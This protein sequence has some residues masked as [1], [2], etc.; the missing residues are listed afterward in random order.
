MSPATLTPRRRAHAP[1]EAQG[2]SR[3]DVALLVAWRG[4]GELAHGRFRELWRFV[5]PGD[6][7][8]VNTSATLPAAL[9]G[10]VDGLAVELNL[11][12]QAAEGD[13]IVELRTHD[14]G[15]FGPPPIGA[16]VELPAGARAHLLAPYAGGRRLCLARLSL[17]YPLEDYLRRHGRPI[18]YPHAD[19]AWPIDA[20]QTVFALHPGSAE[21]PSA[22]RPFS[23]DLVTALV[24]RGVLLAPIT[25][26]T[27][28][29]SLERGEAPHPERYQV[30]AATAQL[31]N[32]V[33]AWGGRVIAV[34]TSVV[35]ALETVARP[36][37]SIAAGAGLTDLIVTPERGLTAV[38][39]LL[40]GW[41]EP[42]SSHL[43]LL[44]AAAGAELFDRSYRAA[45][46]H[47]YRRH[48]FGDSHLILP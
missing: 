21:M 26:H 34:G 8:V 9:P 10:Q 35:R 24:A 37:R 2:R 29:S 14:R 13:W 11:S 20:Y 12:T 3:D 32:A 25:L 38:D 45:Y 33:H 1:P 48:E 22:G 4:S 27:G 18:R 42:D 43:D 7:L 6:L 44:E 47:G 23:P 16:V 39:G 46:A 40:T 15:R 31:V 5:G 41:H 36:D 28:V 17:P 19:E 30:S